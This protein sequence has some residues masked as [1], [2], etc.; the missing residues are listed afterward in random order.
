MEFISLSTRKSIANTVTPIKLGAY[1]RLV[2]FLERTSPDSLIMR[3]Q[4]ND[5]TNMDLQRA[6]LNNIR[7]EYEH[8][9]SQQLYVSNQASIVVKNAKESITQLINMSA[10][11]V[12]PN[13]NSTK[14]AM[15]IIETYYSVENPPAKIAIDFLRTELKS[16]FG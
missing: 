6:L 11:Q 7:Q 9:Y 5:M 14:L 2:L 16:Y 1:E 3:V 4:R 8:N 12:D 15:L 10:A 13:E